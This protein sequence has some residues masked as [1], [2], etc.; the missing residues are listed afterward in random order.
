MPRP[1]KRRRIEGELTVAKRIAYEREARGWTYESLARHVTEAGCP[2]N[3]SA[4]YKI[5]KADPPRRIVVD[6]LVAF[7]EVFG[8]TLDEM[9]TPALQP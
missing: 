7:A 5:E 6:E 8:L 4:I 2:L 3:G 1:N 9:F